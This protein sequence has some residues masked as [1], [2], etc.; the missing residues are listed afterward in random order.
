MPQRARSAVDRCVRA[1]L[2][3]ATGERS[4]LLANFYSRNGVWRLR[5]VGQGYQANL[6]GLAVMHGVDIE[7]S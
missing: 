4:L 5:A 3:A 1:T 2:D 7:E 6:A